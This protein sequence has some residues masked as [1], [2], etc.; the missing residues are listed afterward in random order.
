ME[1]SVPQICPLGLVDGKFCLS[2][3]RLS[4]FLGDVHWKS[5]F[6]SIGSHIGVRVILAGTVFFLF[7][8]QVWFPQFRAR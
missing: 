5:D 7:S 1:V 3:W 6:G 2:S 4:R 8:L